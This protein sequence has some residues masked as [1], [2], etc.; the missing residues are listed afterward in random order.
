MRKTRVTY[1]DLS[2]RNGLTLYIGYTTHCVSVLQT[3]LELGMPADYEPTSISLTL[4]ERSTR[5]ETTKCLEL[6]IQYH[7]DIN[8]SNGYAIRLAVCD[9][10][11]D[12]TDVLIKAGADVK[13]RG[14][15]GSAIGYALMY[16]SHAIVLR[17]LSAGATLPGAALK[18]ARYTGI[19]RQLKI[20]FLHSM[21]RQHKPR[22]IL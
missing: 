13:L 8:R 7:A 1:T 21:S 19:D 9:N 17:L 6:L 14:S 5:Y 12:M 10:R 20:D 2:F 18:L 11:L 16:A 15:G 4:L 22:L 3:C